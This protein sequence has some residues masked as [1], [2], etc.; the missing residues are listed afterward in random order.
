MTLT[1]QSKQRVAQSRDNRGNT[2]LADT[3][4][5]LSARNYIHR[6]F[7]QL[8]LPHQ[9]IIVEVALLHLTTFEGYLAVEC[10]GQPED[11]P[12]FDLIFHNARVNHLATIHSTGHLVHLDNSVLQT[13]FHH[14]C[15][16]GSK[17]LEQRYTAPAT[18]R[19]GRIPA[20]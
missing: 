5:R 4:W 20:G 19:N 3:G 8:V 18:F 14:L 7:R 1:G 13:G 10:G 2:R 16:K 15:N 17:A 9:L 12:A 6:Y 11:N